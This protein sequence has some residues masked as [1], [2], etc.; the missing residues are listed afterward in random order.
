VVH[1]KANVASSLT[2]VWRQLFE[3][4]DIT[5]NAL[6][7]F[8]PGCMKTTPVHQLLETPTETDKQ[9]HVYQKP[10]RDVNELNQHLI[11]TWST[12]SRATVIKRLISGQIV[13][14]SVSRQKNKH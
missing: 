4:Q 10:V 5:V 14:M 2:D 7:T 13:L 1:W 12:T 3:Q 9:E 6:F 8:T 11:E